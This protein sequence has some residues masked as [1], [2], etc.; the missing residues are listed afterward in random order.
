MAQVIVQQGQFVQQAPVVVIMQQPQRWKVPVCSTCTEDCGECCF[1]L[2]CPQ[3]AVYQQRKRL[4]A[5]TGEPYSFLQQESF[6]RMATCCSDAYYPPPRTLPP[7]W[8]PAP[9]TNPMLDEF[10]P[11]I[12]IESW[13]CLGWAML[14]NRNL[15]KYKFFIL[16][17]TCEKIMT[18]SCLGNAVVVADL[19]GGPGFT[20]DGGTGGA[21]FACLHTQGHLQLR[22]EEEKRISMSSSV[23]VTNTGQVVP[24]G[25][26][27]A[28]TM[29]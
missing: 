20:N 26:P 9:G 14:M 12:C 23:L 2:Y 15:I 25:S 22:H 19:G 17:G 27:V 18:C 11:G 8:P 16:D 4:L 29:G 28:Q 24:L 13:F 21:C 5:F 1:A 7:V 3:C 6:P 10:Q